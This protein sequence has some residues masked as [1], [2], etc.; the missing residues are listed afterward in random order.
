MPHVF[1]S[2]STDD[3]PLAHQLRAALTSVGV[4]TFVASVSVAAGKNWTDSVFD[5]LR[6]SEWVFFIASKSSCASH[7]VQ[8]E[9]G[10]SLAQKKQIIPI[11]IDVAPSELPGW[12]G[13]HQAI[14][15]RANADQLNRTIAAIGQQVKSQKFWSGV[16]LGGIALALIASRDR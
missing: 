14:D 6:A 12:V 13:Q 3:E 1:I 8:Q 15:A 4:D 9:I 7:F 10:A 11:L 16:I 5:A 2:C